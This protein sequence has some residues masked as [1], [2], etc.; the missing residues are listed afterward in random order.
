MSPIFSRPFGQAGGPAFGFLER[1]GAA[2]HRAFG[3]FLI[4]VQKVL[5]QAG[6][7]QRVVIQVNPGNQAYALSFTP[8][9]LTLNAYDA[10]PPGALRNG[11]RFVNTPGFG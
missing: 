10:I 2:H 8:A 4:S 1:D 3:M 11:F 5:Q 6:S 7:G 9:G